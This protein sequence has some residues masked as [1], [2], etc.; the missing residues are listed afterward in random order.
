MVVMGP[1]FHGNSIK[2]ST[3]YEMRAY[4]GRAHRGTKMK[5]RVL[6]PT[7]VLLSFAAFGQ[8]TAPLPGQAPQTQ[9]AASAALPKGTTP[10]LP[11][12]DAEFIQDYTIGA[13]D[14]ISILVYN[15]PSFTA[16]NL[17][18]RPDGYVSMPLVR[19]LKAMGKKPS[20]LEDEIA[21]T[22][23]EKF[24]KYT[25]R[26]EVRIDKVNSRY[27]SIDG[28]VN[29][30]GRYDLLV[31]TTLMQALVNAGGFHDFADKKHIKL[32]RNGKVL[33]TFNWND[34][35]QGKHPE[36]NIFLKHG[37]LIIVKE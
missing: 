31:P 19:E 20:E 3:I 14:Q 32:L 30:P 16:T 36:N 15:E 29:K 23:A 7:I 24:L 8:T 2:C 18:V 21:Q 1:R 35:V 11:K 9:P 13:E 12:P 33:V 4:A 34:A 25:P 17:V 27:F 28:A 5:L 22:L 6:P 10:Q 37:D 26:V